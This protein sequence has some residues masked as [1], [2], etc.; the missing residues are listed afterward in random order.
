[1]K[2]FLQHQGCRILAALYGEYTVEPGFVEVEFNGTAGDLVTCYALSANQELVNIGLRPS[3]YHQ[4]RI[5]SP[6]W[7]PDLNR[8]VS[9]R[10][11]EIETERIRRNFL[12][13]IYDGKNLDADAT[14][15]KNLSDKLQGVRERIRLGIA[16]APEL[17]VWKD[18]DNIVYSWPDLQGYHDWLSRYTIALEERGTRLYLA[19]W[20]HKTNIEALSTVE[21]I[22]AYD[23]TAGWPV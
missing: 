7:E 23:I 4:S 16:M 2:Y 3:P 20:Q 6:G 19:W 5:D 15:Q 9:A 12:P 22:L 1:M 11:I 21:E 18:A 17:L 14:A 13:I 8:A 10:K